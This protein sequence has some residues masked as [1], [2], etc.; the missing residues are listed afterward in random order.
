MA[1]DG[2]AKQDLHEAAKRGI[3]D[4]VKVTVATHNISA[5]SIS[6]VHI[7]HAAASLSTNA[8]C[9]RTCLHAHVK[10]TVRVVSVRTRCGR[11]G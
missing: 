2:R 1:I 5:V 8:Q 6:D 4:K 11:W 3:G 7:T 9:S 10:L